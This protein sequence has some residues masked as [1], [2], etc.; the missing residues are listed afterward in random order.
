MDSISCSLSL[1]SGCLNDLLESIQK[2]RYKITLIRI[3]TVSETHAVLTNHAIQ[4]LSMKSLDILLHQCVSL[5]PKPPRLS[6]SFLPMPGWRR[7][8]PSG[9]SRYVTIHS[10][11]TPPAAT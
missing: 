3:T 6:W 8:H 2:K 11:L 4:K 5:I 9:S 10:P 1:L 7:H